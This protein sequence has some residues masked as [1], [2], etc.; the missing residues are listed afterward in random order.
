MTPPAR[1]LRARLAATLG[2]FSLDAD[3]NVRAGE[4]LVLLGPNGSGKT[5]CLDLIAGLRTPDRGH[6][7]LDETVLCDTET[8]V[9]LAPEDRRVGL[10]FQDYALF[11]HLSVRENV[12]YGARARRLARDERARVTDE[13]LARLDMAA[14]ADR[15]VT[16][17]SGGQRQRVALARALASDARILLLD[18]PFASLDATTRAAVRAELR[19]FLRAAALPAL[20]VTHDP[21]DAFVVGDR[22]A[23][24][25]HG[26][27][28]QTGTS[29]DLLAHPRTPFVADLVGLNVYEASLAA[30]AGLKEARA[31]AVV[32]HVLADELA[33]AV[34]LAFAPSDVALA[35]APPAGSFQN[36]FEVR[37]LDSLNLPDRLRVILDAGVPMA[38]DITREAGRALPLVPGS[39]LWA[40]VKATSIRVYP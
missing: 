12:A 39:T 5:T 4:T 15:A 19:A 14:L 24:I 32:F 38:S 6:I 13:S 36:A 1:G 27:I 26:R 3:I 21:L 10:V 9:D 35:I 25:E 40:M 8:G 28:V 37:V 30:G 7:T 11:P 17:L 34:H 29:D 31:G 20:V 2:A 22:L 23:V 16:Q 18:E 33:G